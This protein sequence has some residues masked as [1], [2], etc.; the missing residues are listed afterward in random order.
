MYAFQA[1]V[2]LYQE[3]NLHC[4]LFDWAMQIILNLLSKNTLII[5]EEMSVINVKKE[6][7]PLPSKVLKIHTY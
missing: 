2:S 3:G 5:D 6:R 1:H 4:F 7:R